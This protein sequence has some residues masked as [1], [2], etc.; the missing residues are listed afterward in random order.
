MRFSYTKMTSEHQTS[1][2]LLDAVCIR[3]CQWF[4]QFSVS[5][6]ACSTIVSSYCFAESNLYG[7]INDNGQPSGSSSV[8][9]EYI[10]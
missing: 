3:S 9:I 6:T 7:F 5:E 1:E 2:S 4:I 10:E 8:H